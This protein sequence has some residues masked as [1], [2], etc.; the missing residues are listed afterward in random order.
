L[1]RSKGSG[2]D[3]TKPKRDANATRERILK[4]GISEFCAHGY[5]GSRIDKI[6]ARAKCNIRMIYHYFGNKEG[7]YLA[8]LERVY[9]LIRQRESELALRELPPVE[10]IKRLVEFTFDHHAKH[11]EFVELAVV[12]NVQKGRF[13]KKSKTISD[14]TTDLIAA[15]TEVLSRGE[16]QGIFRRGT[17]ALQLYL[18]I[19]SLSFL[20]L[21][22]KYTLSI[23]YRCELDSKD[24]LSQ[25]RE[26]VLQMVLGYLIVGDD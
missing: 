11:R 3:L 16:Q 24:W 8:A 17:D 20:H 6:A 2:E 22:N 7:L 9:G 25:R 4:V 19:L 13:L 15:I 1:Q 5:S 21:S 12:E 18:S 14:G 23:M 26:H 10:A